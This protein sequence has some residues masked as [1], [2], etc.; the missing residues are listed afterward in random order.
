MKQVCWWYGMDRFSRQIVNVD[1]SSKDKASWDCRVCRDVQ[2]LE[3]FLLEAVLGK[4]ALGPVPCP[5][6]QEQDVFS[7]C[8]QHSLWQ[9]WLVQFLKSFICDKR[10]LVFQEPILSFQFLIQYEWAQFVIA[11]LRPWTVNQ[12]QPRSLIRQMNSSWYLAK[13]KRKLMITC[14]NVVFLWRQ[15][16]K[17]RC[18]IICFRRAQ[19]P[20]IKG[21]VANK[22]LVERVLVKK[23]VNEHFTD[24]DQRVKWKEGGK[25]LIIQ[26]EANTS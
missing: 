12:D 9:Y 14:D 26:Y 4:L 17:K 22:A 11:S 8:I 10:K 23:M 25:K 19:N 1:I 3:D 16:L 24:E 13:R 7:K 21:K 18:L 2:D 5:R 20:Q 6:Q 15:H